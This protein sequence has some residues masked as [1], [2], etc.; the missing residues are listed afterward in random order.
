MERHRSTIE[1][2]AKSERHGITYESLFLTRPVQSCGHGQLEAHFA[3]SNSDQ[4]STV[5][6]K[7]RNSGWPSEFKKT[8]CSP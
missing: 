5:S 4:L 8:K 1:A 2:V 3:S 6:N 7:N